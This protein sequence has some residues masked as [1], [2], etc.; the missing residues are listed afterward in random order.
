MGLR[1][2]ISGREHP[3]TGDACVV[4]LGVRDIAFPKLK[5]RSKFNEWHGIL[6]RGY[7]AT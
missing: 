2:Q 6:H 3:Q 4:G 5:A 7:R 1:F